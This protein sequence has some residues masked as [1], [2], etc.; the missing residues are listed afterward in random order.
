M[1]VGRDAVAFVV[2]GFE[3][4]PGRVV[5]VWSGLACL[6]MVLAQLL[7]AQSQEAQGSSLVARHHAA[8]YKPLNRA[9]NV[10]SSA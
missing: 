6:T 2:D 9:T 3:E 1:D 5:F 7:L 4:L 8:K 10:G